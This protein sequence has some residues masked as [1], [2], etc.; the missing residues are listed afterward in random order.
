MILFAKKRAGFLSGRWT[1]NDHFMLLVGTG[2]RKQCCDISFDADDIT[3]NYYFAKEALTAGEE[4][5]Q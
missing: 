4:N 3:A 5:K 2:R 1:D